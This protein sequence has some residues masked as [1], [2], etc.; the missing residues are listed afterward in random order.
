[1]RDLI[2]AGIEFRV[3]LASWHAWINKKLGGNMDKIKEAAEHFKHAFI[4]CGIPKEKVRFI[5]PEEE[6]K[7][8]S[9]WE[10]VLA[11]SKEL[12][13]ARAL[14]TVEIMG[15]KQADALHV[16]DLIYTPMQVADIFQFDIDI[17]QLGM[18]QRKANVVAREIGEKIG[19]WKP[20]CVHTHLLQGLATPP[21]WP[22][23]SDPTA[24]KEVLASIKMSKSKPDTCIFIYDSPEEIKRK[25]SNAF[26]P[27]KETKFNPVLDIAKNIVFREKE[28]FEIKRA[29]RFG[30]DLQFES[31]ESLE[32]AFADGKLHPADL[33]LAT[34]DVLIDV[35]TPVR[36][37]F[38]KNE[39]AKWT[40]EMMNKFAITR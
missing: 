15:R 27:A 25:M 36:E 39:D 26:C 5:E 19:F 6:Y 22:L 2:E 34:A 29:E 14:R 4:A 11:V 7:E 16:S 37:Y 21:I 3:Y 20:I 24:Q 8:I 31:Y 32:K 13:I 1:M 9:Y 17:C 10:K 18:D 23:P 33:K 38:E 12:T 40:L 30:G 28:V 35:L